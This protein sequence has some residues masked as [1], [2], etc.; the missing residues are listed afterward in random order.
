MKV[1]AEEYSQ[2]EDGLYVFHS[3]SKF[4]HLYW[5]EEVML[6]PAK[7]NCYLLMSLVEYLTE[8]R[9]TILDP[10]SGTGT[11]MLGA[12]LNRK[13]ICVEVEDGYHAMQIEAYNN[14]RKEFPNVT[15]DVVLIQSNC[16][17]VLPIPAD[18]V[19]FSPPYGN[20]FTMKKGPSRVVG[21]LSKSMT[22]VADYSK[23]PYNVGNLNDFMYFKVMRKIYQQLYMSAPLMAVVVKDRIRDGELY[24]FVTMTIKECRNVGWKFVEEIQFKP[25]GSI[26]TKINMA[27]GKAGIEYESIV[28]MRR[29]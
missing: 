23:S 21:E 15:N 10:M 11:T 3:D 17:K 16:A 6:Q 22:A 7:F 27:Q 13:V 9:Q 24:P 19:I 1:F 12:M 18:V 25:S 14:L 29:E 5:P 26:Y 8:P 20:I 2:D 28:V 4:R